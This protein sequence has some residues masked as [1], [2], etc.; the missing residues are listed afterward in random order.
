MKIIVT[1]YK[2]HGK[3]TFCNLLG[4]DWAGSSATVF[5]DIIFPVLKEK[6]GYTTMEE[7]MENKEKHRAEMFEVIS[8]YNTPNKARLIAEIFKEHDVYNGLRCVDELNEAKA[9]GLIDLV[10][11]VDASDRLP[12]E[13]NS[14]MTITP[15]DCDLVITNNTSRNDFASKVSK[16]AQLIKARTTM[17]YFANKKRFPV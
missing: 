17:V 11:W 6:Y 16:V 8:N 14:S 4:L 12:P 13:A 9:Q 7:C 2:N 5:D 3:D 1:G 15:N 10:I